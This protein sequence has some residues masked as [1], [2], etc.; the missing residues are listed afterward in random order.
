[1]KAADYGR[2]QRS[3][4]PLERSATWERQDH[5]FRLLESAAPP[6]TRRPGRCLPLAPPR[7]PRPRRR[8]S[9]ASGRAGRAA[10]RAPPPVAG[11]G[12]GTVGV[13]EGGLLY[14]GVGEGGLRYRGV[15]EGGFGV[16]VCVCVWNCLQTA[17]LTRSSLVVLTRVRGRCCVPPAA[18]RDPPARPASSS[19]RAPRSCRTR[20][21]VDGCGS[22]VT[23]I[24]S[25]SSLGRAAPQPND[26]GAEAAR[27]ESR[28]RADCPTS[29]QAP[30]GP[31]GM[32]GGYAGTW[33][34]HSGE[35]G[36][37]DSRPWMQRCRCPVGNKRKPAQRMLGAL[38]SSPA[39]HV[40]VITA[41]QVL[42]VLE[43]DI[44]W[45]R[46]VARIGEILAARD[47]HGTG[48][49]WH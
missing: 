27:G 13:R 47:Q 8:R 23:R 6:P 25:G 38:L 41:L 32:H 22:H 37:R 31:G 46:W 48:A 30:H 4:C 15:G 1:M 20:R 24:W 5:A 14:R 28:R 26:G 35:R 19:G 29:G 44:L 42:Q 18:S 40:R 2:A 49:H 9:R 10:P 16:C 12:S 3:A 36:E 11:L 45:P 7:R 21:E 33:P 17:S 34:R 43:V 39:P